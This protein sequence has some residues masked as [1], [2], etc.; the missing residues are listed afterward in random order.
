M[1]FWIS[2]GRNVTKPPC[3]PDPSRES[4]HR[5]NA[6]RRTA[7]CSIHR[8]R[9]GLPPPSIRSSRHCPRTPRQ[10]LKVYRTR[11]ARV[12]FSKFGA[13]SGRTAPRPLPGIRVCPHVDSRRRAAYAGSVPLGYV[14]FGN[15]G[16]HAVSVLFQEIP[17]IGANL[18]APA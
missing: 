7:A 9:E 13:Y 17:D 5:W 12:N 6:R 15:V 10:V 4:G 11:I 8:E 16:Q 1:A 3:P 2:S 18:P 14:R